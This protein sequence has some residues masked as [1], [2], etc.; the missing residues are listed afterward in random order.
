MEEHKTGS[1]DLKGLLARFEAQR[2]AIDEAIS[3]I[4]KVLAVGGGDLPLATGG[5]GGS[6]GA[7][8]IKADTFFGMNIVEAT[9]KYLSMVNKQPQT[10]AQIIEALTRGGQGSPTYATV[11]A[12]LA[13][14]ARQ[15]GG[16]AK[17]NKNDWG[18][19]QWYPSV[20][21]KKKAERKRKEG[22]EA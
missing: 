21:R 22:A 10:T 8:D 14:D 17:V 16:L 3:A 11:Y 15:G 20:P 19:A 6:Y 5:G 18:L 12:V 1:T 4:K 9:K 13:R 7:G 2:A